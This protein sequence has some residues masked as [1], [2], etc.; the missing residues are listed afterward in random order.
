M[1]QGDVDTVRVEVMWQ[2]GGEAVSAVLGVF[3]AA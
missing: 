1:G 3:Q 2:D